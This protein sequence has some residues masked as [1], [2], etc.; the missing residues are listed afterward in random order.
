V[1]PA[2][3]AR[4]WTIGIVVGV[5]AVATAACSDAEGEESEPDKA[6]FCEHL[7]AAAGLTLA[8]DQLD[9]DALR[10]LVP[11]LE[12]AVTVAPLDIRPETSDVA[13][14]AR[15]VLDR[16]DAADPLDAAAAAEAFRALDDR[17][18]ETEE[19]GAALEEFALAQC[20]VD[21]RN[22]PTSTTTSPPTTGASSST[23]EAPPTTAAVIGTTTV[24]TP[25]PTASIPPDATTV[26]DGGMPTTSPPSG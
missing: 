13:G 4:R 25:A 6:A 17:R 2:R 9:L 23:S 18:A 8:F 26:P 21:L 20:D 3:R 7:T 11:E 22:P 24:W 10:V 14:Y 5:T 15:A 12:E 16:W 1:S 19:S